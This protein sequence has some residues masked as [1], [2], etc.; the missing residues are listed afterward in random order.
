[1]QYA[2]LWG[3][4]AELPRWARAKARR[5]EL[6]TPA[7][8]LWQGREAEAARERVKAKRKPRNGGN[9]EMTGAHGERVGFKCGDCAHL[10][11][12][13]HSGGEYFKCGKREDTNGPGSDHRLYWG[14]CGL[15]EA[16]PKT[17]IPPTPVRRPLKV[18][19]PQCGAEVTL[20]AWYPNDRNLARHY[21]DGRDEQGLLKVQHG[22][23]VSIGPDGEVT[24]VE[25]AW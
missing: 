17:M 3:D 8:T 7:I 13:K 5:A 12:K 19:C 4:E 18:T 20:R 22:L 2:T 11:R 6:E 25:R 21:V 15:F 24:K 10:F 14:A 23:A 1:M 9:R 16:R